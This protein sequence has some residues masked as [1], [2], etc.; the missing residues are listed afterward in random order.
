MNDRLL[1]FLGLCRRAGYLLY[2]AQ[3]AINAMKDGKAL[4]TLRASDLSP[5]SYRDV[6]FTA[7]KCGVPMRTLGCTKEQLSA[8][9]GKLCGVV[10]VTDRGFAD[11]LLTM[12]NINEDTSYI[13]KEE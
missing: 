8:A 9:V 3:T 12:I 13:V 2:G 4:L 1:S 10:C 7:G 5:N 6:E 11:K